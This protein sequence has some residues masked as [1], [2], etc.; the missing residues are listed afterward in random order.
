MVLANAYFR[1]KRDGS[2]GY[3]LLDYIEQ[4]NLEHLANIND[5]N[6]Q[7]I[8]VEVKFIDKRKV[9][10]LQRNF[11]FALLGDIVNWSGE[12]KEIVDDY[13]RSLYWE[14]NCGQEISLKDTTENTVSDAKKLIDLVI[15]FVFD[16]QVPIKRGYELLPRNEEHFQYECLVHRQCL[17]C[18]Q[19]ADI[20]HIDEVGMGRDRTKLNHTKFRLMALCRAHHTEFHKIGPIEFCSKYHLT[21]PGIKLN[22]IDLEKI[23]VKGNYQK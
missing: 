16:N 10:A 3:G 2:K 7:G 13:F 8:P 17:I 23:G 9:S 12:D 15:D 11:Y 20:H 21:A 22:V 19:P 5:G 18:G 4:P 6:V 14:K 1:R